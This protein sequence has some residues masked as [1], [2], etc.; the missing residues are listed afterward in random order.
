MQGTDAGHGQQAAA[1]LVFGN[2]QG[3]RE[4][5][6]PTHH[7]STVLWLLQ[8]LSD[9]VPV[10]PDQIEVLVGAAAGSAHMGTATTGSH[11]CDEPAAVLSA[12]A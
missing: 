7:V 11:S 4:N 3:K 10:D 6:Q 8:V 12:A 1:M 2:H 5:T 9:A